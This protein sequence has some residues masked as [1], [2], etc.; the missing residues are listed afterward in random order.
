MEGENLKIALKEVG[1]LIKDKLKQGAKDDEFVASGK[2]D[3][4]FK[5]RVIANELYIYGEEYAG[6]LSDGVKRDAGY[7]KVGEEFTNSIIRWAKIKGMRPLRRSKSGQFT[8]LKEYSYKSMAIAIAKSIRRKGISQ[9]FGYKG[10]GFIDRVIKEQE[11]NVSDIL[12][13]AY[14]KDILNNLE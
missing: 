1:K 5:Y 3:K 2:L 4:S 7:N 13:E 8:S 9:R 6:A 11:Q 10:S 12:S 14:K